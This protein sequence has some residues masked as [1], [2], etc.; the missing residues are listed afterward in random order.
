MSRP[1]LSARIT[2][3]PDWLS[4]PAITLL[5]A[6]LVTGMDSPVTSDSSSEERPSRMTPST[7]TFSPGRTRKLSPTASVSI[8]TSWSAPSSPIR[9]AVFGASWSSALIAPDV[10]SRAR[11]SSTW[12]SSTSTVMTAADFEIDRDRAAMAAEGRREDSGRDGADDAVEIGHAG[13][14]RDQREHVEIARDAAI[15]SRARRTASRPT[16]RRAWRRRTGSSSTAS[17]RPSHDRRR[18][19]RPFPAR[20]PAARARGRSRTGASCRRVRDWAAHR[21]SRPPAPAPCRRS[22]SFPGRPGG[23]PDASG[24]CR[25]CLPARRP[26]A[27][28]LS[29]DRRSG[30]AANLVRQ[31]AEQKWKVSPRWSKRC[32]LVAGIDRHAADGIAHGCGGVGVMIVMAVTAWSWPAWPPPHGSLWRAVSVGVFV[33]VHHSLRRLQPIPCRGI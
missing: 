4:V 32:L 8:S 16:A 28:C 6:S 11:S 14:D 21:G 29:R 20:P 26:S 33:L 17:G 10:A 27:C 25:S 2:N 1:T 15:A 31:P 13:A 22:G 23:S 9:R 24:R 7:G 12:P 19:G 18:D 5:P 30:S 3:P